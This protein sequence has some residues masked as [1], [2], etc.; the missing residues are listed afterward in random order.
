MTL[1]M[2]AFSEKCHLVVSLLVM[3]LSKD[4]KRY[5]NSHLTLRET[6][7]ANTTITGLFLC[8]ESENPS[9]VTFS[10]ALLKLKAQRSNASFAKIQ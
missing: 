8:T 6:P 5:Q 9:G 4:A 3:S 10:K 7:A 2:A 1:R